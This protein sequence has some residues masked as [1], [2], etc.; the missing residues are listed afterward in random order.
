VTVGGVGGNNPTPDPRDYVRNRT[1]EPSPLLAT[2]VVLPVTASL[3]GRGAVTELA[4]SITNDDSAE[5]TD[6]S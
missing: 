4:A 3:T 2:G 5:D 6:D 1:K